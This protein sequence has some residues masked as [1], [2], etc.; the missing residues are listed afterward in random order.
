MPEDNV[1]DFPK[2]E[3]EAPVL[4]KDQLY[5]QEFLQGLAEAEQKLLAIDNQRAELNAGKAEIMAKLI[6]FGLNKDAVKAAIKYFRT[7]ED[8]RQH[9]DLSYQV[10]RKA[11]NCPMQDDLFVAAAQKAVN[12]HQGKK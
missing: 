10:M 1:T 12:K 11:L 3:S 9:F 8:K 5:D 7:P 4:D 6:N 2:Q